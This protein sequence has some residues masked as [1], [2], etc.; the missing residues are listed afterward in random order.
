MYNLQHDGRKEYEYF[1]SIIRFRF[2]GVW[3]KGIS[4]HVS[5]HPVI[6][7]RKFECSIY[8]NVL[9]YVLQMNAFF[10]LNIHAMLHIRPC[11]VFL[12]LQC[13][14]TQL[15]QLLCDLR[16]VIQPFWAFLPS[17]LKWGQ[18]NLLCRAVT[19]KVKSLWNV[20]CYINISYS[21]FTNPNILLRNL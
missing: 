17:S 9:T 7:K 5:S 10:F 2:L 15:D 20:M 16:Q 13:T 19:G 11:S 21:C 12:W 6:P 18:Q 3:Q 8:T 4:R 1:S 14:E